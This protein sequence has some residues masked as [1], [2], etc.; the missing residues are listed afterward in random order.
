MQVVDREDH[1]V[2]SR[3]LKMVHAEFVRG[4]AAARGT[5]GGMSCAPPAT[6]E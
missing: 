1:E 4:D 2:T 5:V 3:R 6:V